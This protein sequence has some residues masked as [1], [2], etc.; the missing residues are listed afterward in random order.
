[1]TS[2]EQKV[3]DKVE[4]EEFLNLPEHSEKCSSVVAKSTRLAAEIMLK[5]R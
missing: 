2:S 3:L 1:M 5:G 4:R